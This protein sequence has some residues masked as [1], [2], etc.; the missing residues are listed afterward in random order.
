M[1]LHS[2]WHATA[3]PSCPL[4]DSD[5]EAKGPFQREQPMQSYPWQL[6]RLHVHRAVTQC[7]ACRRAG[8]AAGLNSPSPAA[9]WPGSAV[10]A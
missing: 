3:R 10:G 2:T 4:P 9:S 8:A 1:P 5:T 6:G 7:W